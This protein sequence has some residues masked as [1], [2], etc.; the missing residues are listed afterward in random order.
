V[1]IWAVFQKQEKLMVLVEKC[2][3]EEQCLFTVV[4]LDH[5]SD[6]MELELLSDIID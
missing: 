4:G 6:G 5:L 1:F 2:H 3:M